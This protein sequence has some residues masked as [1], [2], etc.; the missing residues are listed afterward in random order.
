MI[1]GQRCHDRPCR[2]QC[3]S[4]QEPCLDKWEV[5]SAR[6]GNNGEQLGNLRIVIGRWFVHVVIEGAGILVSAVAVYRYVSA[7]GISVF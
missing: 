4:C 6:G 7:E 2:N 1:E 3:R 5:V